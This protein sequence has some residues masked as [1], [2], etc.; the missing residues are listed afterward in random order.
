MDTRGT[1]TFGP[2]PE[3]TR[4]SWEVELRGALKLL[5]PIMG[6]SVG[7]RSKPTAGGLKQVPRKA[8]HEYGVRMGGPRAP[9]FLRAQLC[10]VR[11]VTPNGGPPRMSPSR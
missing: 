4:W 7:A 1:V 3:G 9:V 11:R 8:E 6:A 2:V 5:T 10:R